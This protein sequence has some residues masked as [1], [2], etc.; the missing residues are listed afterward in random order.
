MAHFQN[1]YGAVPVSHDP[2]QKE[3]NAAG[4]TTGIG[5]TTHVAAA[6]DTT[7]PAMIDTAATTATATDENVTTNSDGTLGSEKEYQQ[8]KGIMEKI[9][10]KLPGKHHH[11]K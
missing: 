4:N 2:I 8:K 1:Q 6:D 7:G 11:N 10:E 5:G 9:K 3:M